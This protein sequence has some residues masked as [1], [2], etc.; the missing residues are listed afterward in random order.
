MTW[1]VRIHLKTER[2]GVFGGVQFDQNERVKG[3]R[4]EIES[5][6]LTEG[7]RIVHIWEDLLK[8]LNLRKVR[9]EFSLGTI[10]WFEK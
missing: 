8:A 1:P 7:L 9:E 3:E 5:L 4:Q 2:I 6:E 10:P